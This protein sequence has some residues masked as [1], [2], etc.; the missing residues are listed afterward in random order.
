MSKRLIPNYTPVE[1]RK[2]KKATNKQTTQK[3]GPRCQVTNHLSPVSTVS[4]TVIVEKY[5][6]H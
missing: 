3:K 5:Y 2:E 6:C 4:I 1:K